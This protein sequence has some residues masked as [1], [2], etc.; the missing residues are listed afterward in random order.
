MQNLKNKNDLQNEFVN[1]VNQINS[2]KPFKETANAIFKKREEA[3]IVSLDKKHKP[4]LEKNTEYK[5]INQIRILPF[6]DQI[7]SSSG[8]YIMGCSQCKLKSKDEKD[9][10]GAN[11]Y[12]KMDKI[13]MAKMF[14]SMLEYYNEIH[15]TLGREV[16]ILNYKNGLLYGREDMIEFIK[17]FLIKN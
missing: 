9:L 15:V 7:S 16:N 3:K 5:H 13:K 12:G 8:S 2:N 17:K 10:L 14:I 1:F 4:L 6:A 11:G